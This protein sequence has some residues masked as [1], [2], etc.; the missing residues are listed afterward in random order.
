MIEIHITV[1]MGQAGKSVTKMFATEKSF[2]LFFF[3]Y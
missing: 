3:I 2:I 1:V